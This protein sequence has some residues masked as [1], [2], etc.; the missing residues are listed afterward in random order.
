M[1]GSELQ[2]A[3]VP[4]GAQNGTAGKLCILIEPKF[5]LVY[6][7]SQSTVS[8]SYVNSNMIQKRSLTK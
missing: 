7:H 1:V 3:S 4:C 8:W 5:Q 6:K 2:V